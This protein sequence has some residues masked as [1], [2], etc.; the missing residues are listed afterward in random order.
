[1]NI[2]YH[3]EKLHSCCFE[4]RPHEIEFNIRL[5]SKKF[6]NGEFDLND[7][8]KKLFKKIIRRMMKYQTGFW[9]K[10]N[11]DYSILYYALEALIDKR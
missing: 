2:S 11:I 10:P 1:M 6:E 4:S 5:L 9:D 3:L 7:F 8:E